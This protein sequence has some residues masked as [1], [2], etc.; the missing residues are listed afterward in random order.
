MDEKKLAKECSPVILKIFR[1][2]GTGINI[3][4]FEAIKISSKIKIISIIRQIIKT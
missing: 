4:R 1:K 2:D 3:K